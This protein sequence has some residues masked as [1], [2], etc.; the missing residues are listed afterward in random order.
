[1]KT[2]TA[3][4]ML[5]LGLAASGMAAEFK[6][7]VED[8]SCSTKPAMKNDA[9]CAQKCIKGIKAD[10]ARNEQHL[11]ESMAVATALVPKIGY[12]RVSKLT[13]QS[14]AEGRSLVTI[15]EESGLFSTDDTIAAIRKASHPVFDA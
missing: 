8:T 13:R 5:A 15:L 11:M 7:F 1:M 2:L 12:A 4:T 6:G 9:E 10:V 14:V 3:A